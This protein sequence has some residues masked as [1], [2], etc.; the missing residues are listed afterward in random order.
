MGQ[1]LLVVLPVIRCLEFAGVGIVGQQSALNQVWHHDVL[2]LLHVLVLL[3]QLGQLLPLCIQLLLHLVVLLQFGLDSPGLCLLGF[4]GLFDLL[5]GSSSFRVLRQEAM[6][7]TL[8]DYVEAKGLSELVDHKNYLP[9]V[10]V[11]WLKI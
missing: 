6:G 2:H 11:L 3:P 1:D 9:V 7:D 10:A 5:L 8:A 4:L